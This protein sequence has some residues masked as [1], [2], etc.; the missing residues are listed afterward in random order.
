[1]QKIGL[2][3][4][5][6]FEISWVHKHRF[7]CKRRFAF[8]LT[9][10]PAVTTFHEASQRHR[11]RLAPSAVAAVPRRARPPALLSHDYAGNLP[12]GRSQSHHELPGASDARINELPALRPSVCHERL[13]ARAALNRKSARRGRGAGIGLRQFL[14]LA[15]FSATCT[16]VSRG[17]WE[18]LFAP[19]QASFALR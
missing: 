15:A 18:W 12:S 7:Y 4:H 13:S 19:S 11:I 17:P 16:G 9:S 5:I 6:A 2:R 14:H 1:M 3:S 10:A 8:R